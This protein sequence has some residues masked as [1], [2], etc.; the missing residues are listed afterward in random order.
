MH[1]MRIHFSTGCEMKRGNLTEA[2]R[3]KGLTQTQLAKAIGV[4][5]QT[6]SKYESGK[7]SPRERTWRKLAAILD[8]P[9]DHL[10]QLAD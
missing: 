6:V 2:R 7:A 1:D 4:S 8:K 10:W 3:E 9:V 5:V